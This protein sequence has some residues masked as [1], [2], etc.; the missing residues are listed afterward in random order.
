MRHGTF[1]FD[2]IKPVGTLSIINQDVLTIGNCLTSKFVCKSGTFTMENWS[3][4]VFLYF[5]PIFHLIRCSKY[6]YIV[7]QFKPAED[8]R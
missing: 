8:I 1:K 4:P 3:L 7:I 5:P 2:I 6:P